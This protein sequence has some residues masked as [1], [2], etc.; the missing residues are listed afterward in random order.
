MLSLLQLCRVESKIILGAFK[1]ERTR[2]ADLYGWRFAQ[3]SRN[4]LLLIQKG[5]LGSR[6]TKLLMIRIISLRGSTQTFLNSLGYHNLLTRVV[7]RDT[8][9][10][11]NSCNL[12]QL[13]LFCLLVWLL[14]KTNFLTLLISS[15]HPSPCNTFL[16]YLWIGYILP[17]RSRMWR[18]IRRTMRLICIFSIFHRF[19]I[20][21]RVVFRFDQG[22]YF[23]L[24]RLV[25]PKRIRFKI[26]TTFVSDWTRTPPL[27]H[28]L[29]QF[30][31]FEGL[32]I[33]CYLVLFIFGGNL[34]LISCSIL[35]QLFLKEN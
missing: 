12:C 5:I 19:L 1:Y 3:T 10:V 4:F 23:F 24:A 2:L 17:W 26:A 20:L 34:L 16:A 27:N 31:T 28:P 22:K 15:T 11:A 29:L 33:W 25:L 18:R 21:R 13:S 9:M 30:T 14:F 7:Q 35:G 32:I 6:F 8:L